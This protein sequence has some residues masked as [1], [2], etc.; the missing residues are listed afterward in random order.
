VTTTGTQ[1]S[2]DCVKIDA[3]GN[4]IA[5]GAACGGGGG[6]SVLLFGATATA[7]SAS[8]TNY[9]GFSNTTATEAAAGAYTVPAGTISKLFCTITG[10][11]YATGS[12]TLTMRNKTTNTPTTATG[13]TCTIAATVQNCADG[14]NS[15]TTAAED[16]VDILIIPGS[17]N[18]A[19]ARTLMCKAQFVA[20]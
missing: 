15:I 1:T 14:S 11:V 6:K 4:H 8:G 10:S 19:A 17:P 16:E 20:S 7:A 9:M 13:L 5:A 12:Y 18:P 3:N 2:N